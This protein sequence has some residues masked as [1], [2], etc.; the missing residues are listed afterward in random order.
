M[1]IFKKCSNK[2]EYDN[3][4]HQTKIADILD[5]MNELE[6]FSTIVSVPTGGGKTKIAADFCMKMLQTEGN[7]VIWLSDSIDLLIQSIERFQAMNMF[8]DIYYQLICSTAVYDDLSREKTKKSKY[9]INEEADNLDSKADIVFASVDTIINADKKMLET[10][11]KDVQE[12]GKVYIIY[13]EVH[14]IGAEKVDKFFDYVLSGVEEGVSIL[15]R[16]ALIGL[17]ATIYRHDSPVESFNKWFKNGY[18]EK[19]G[20]VTSNIPYGVGAKELVNNRIEVVSISE[21][22]KQGLLMKPQIIR[23]DDFES[24]LPED[25]MD[26]LA[27]KISKN[28]ETENWNKTIIFVDGKTNAV[29]LQ[30][31]LNEKVSCFVYTSDTATEV[32]EDIKIFKEKKSAKVMIAVDM[33][34]EGFDVKDIETIYMYSKVESHILL[35]QRVG[36]VLRI[37]EGK[38]KATVY[39]QNYF[40]HTNKSFGKY[41]GSLDEDVLEDD[42]EIQ[43][44]IARYKKGMQ[45]PAGMYLE[46]LPTDIETEKVLYR[47][48]EYLRVLELFG[49]DIALEGVGYYEIDGIKIYARLCEQRGYEQ[50]HRIIR[51]DYFSLLIY[52]DKYLKFADYAK[53]LGVSE[54]SLLE[55]I[56]VNCFYMSN[57]SVKD[58]K[59]KIQKKS[60]RVNDNDIKAFY[61]WVVTNDLKIPSFFD[62]TVEPADVHESGDESKFS[63]SLDN[64]VV[65][66]A[67][68][69]YME[70]NN[71]SKCNNMFDGIMLHQEF[72][73]YSDRKRWN[74]A[75]EYPNMLTYGNKQVITY[76]EM[77]SA[78][79]LMEVGAVAESRECGSLFGVEG[80]LALIGRSVDGKYSIKSVIARSVKD[81]YN[82][83]LLLYAQALQTV[84]NHIVVRENDVRE[85][86]D[87]L[88]SSLLTNTDLKNVN[89]NKVTREFIMALGLNDND[90]IIRAQ[91][92]LFANNFPRLLQYVIYN[93]AYVML[94]K[95]VRFV[96]SENRIHSICL[97][98]DELRM[99]YKELLFDFG[100]VQLDVD[101]TPVEDVISDYRPYMKAIP[102]YQGIKPEF[103][104]RM[105]NEMLR[106]GNKQSYHF[107]DSFGGSAT[108][109][110]NIDSN[111]ELQQTYNDLGILNNALFMQLKVDKGSMLKKRIAEF[112]D[113]ILNHTGDETTALA[114]LR[115]YLNTLLNVNDNKYDFKN[116]CLKDIEDIYRQEYDS[117]VIKHNN[118]H[119]EPKWL[120]L[121]DRLSENEYNYAK[122]LEETYKNVSTDELRKIE[123]YLHAILLVL[124]RVFDELKGKKTC[125]IPQV[126]LAFLF[127]VYHSMSARHFYNDATID[128]FAKFI[129]TYEQA[130]GN[131]AEI[132]QKIEIVKGKAEDLLVDRSN[133][134]DCVWY[135]DIP[136]SETSISTYSSD[137]FNES[138]FVEKLGDCKGDYVIASRFNI[139]EARNGNLDLVASKSIEKTDAIRN[140]EKNIIK[141]FGRFVSEEFSKQ[142]QDLVIN[143]FPEEEMDNPD[144]VDPKDKKKANPWTHITDDKTAKYICFAFSQTEAIRS[145]DKNKRIEYVKNHAN[146]SK[147]SIRRMLK[148]TQ[149]SN[150]EVEIMLTNMELDFTK[151][152]VMQLDNESGIWYIP[153]FKTPSTY[154]IEPVTI[155]MEYEK[156]MKEMVLFLVSENI[157]LESEA[158]IEAAAFRRIFE[159]KGM[160]PSLE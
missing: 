28:Y 11:F 106:L 36:R 55:D 58:T 68:R 117:N 156:F 20:I 151:M 50:F 133:V 27:K 34:S 5:K 70:D 31:K 4:S 23:V 51:S 124:T 64:T 78:R 98:E 96:D 40:N 113:L 75:K 47:R 66:A 54:E 41:N 10:W 131:C 101:L 16:F 118:E 57:A 44:D 9:R 148:N 142:Y 146:I 140:K 56:K 129:G 43:R 53:A 135:H 86:M 60:F 38:N 154:K 121:D 134:N 99:S 145:E 125:G 73:R 21:L 149:I 116:I 82:D 159:E 18:D 39:W 110:L 120:L 32:G 29:R 76:N 59:G 112:I 92:E 95:Q 7:K 136:Y 30:K 24:G 123:E 84:P 22:T 15:H 69:K 91:N 35:R 147:D 88:K 42:A 153:S 144:Y 102:Y 130:I 80:E 105:L 48:Y 17:T 127:F 119:K 83:D 8:R 77:C 3:Y 160:L 37:A 126:D 14:H 89:W 62:V 63:R 157:Y 122:I 6:R 65:V 26:Y 25:K 155:I 107:I 46:K 90:D 138:D 141:F 2:K 19:I 128:K 152:P 103:L 45:L 13:D 74:K 49:L 158:R 115:P 139:C 108:I 87:S 109:S 114:F 67:I 143:E 81:I 111:L 71:I 100:I 79:T 97:N 33:V 150:I 104:C 52:K 137:W 61:E 132:L 72:V 93:K 1:Q 94:A 85:Y 12:Q